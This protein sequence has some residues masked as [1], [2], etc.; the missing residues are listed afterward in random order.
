MTRETLAGLG[1]LLLLTVASPLPGQPSATGK[2]AAA[3]NAPMNVTVT[4]RGDTVTLSMV[5]Q[6]FVAPYHVSPGE[7]YRSISE[8]VYGTPK[9]AE[10]LAKYMEQSV[11]SAPG[12]A[13]EGSSERYI[14]VLTTDLGLLA[15]AATRDKVMP[16]IR[17]FLK[18][19]A[20]AA[21][22]HLTFDSSAVSFYIRD[23]GKSVMTKF[24]LNGLIVSPL[25]GRPGPRLRITFDRQPLLNLFAGN[26][27][28]RAAAIEQSIATKP[29]APNRVGTSAP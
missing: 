2:S 27:P 10:M 8:K 22:F 11:D 16:P 15:P 19:N 6:Y 3:A 25:A 21:L 23:D 14:V 20:D 1:V 28:I 5:G 13:K 26:V 7:T 18:G 29:T 17:D 9:Y 12:L 24:T 4:V